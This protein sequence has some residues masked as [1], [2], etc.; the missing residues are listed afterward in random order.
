MNTMK[1]L[2]KREFWEHKG[3]FFWAPMIVG[4]IMVFFL[5]ASIVVGVVL[6]KSHGFEIN[7]DTVTSL[8]GAMTPQEAADF[9]SGLA[10]GYMGLATPL[11]MVL[12]VTVFFFC[13]GALFDDRKDR[14][15]LFWKSLPISDQA[16]VLS[17]VGVALVGAPLITIALGTVVS[18]LSLLAIC[19]GS[20][21]VGVNEFGTVLSSP[22][23]YASPF[24]VAGMLPVYVLWAAPTIGWLMMVSA[25]ARTKPFLWAVGLPVFSGLLLVWFN[26]LFNFGWNVRW[27]WHHIVGRSLGGTIPGVWFAWHPA[28]NGL[29]DSIIDGPKGMAIHRHADDM[30]ALMMQSWDMFR[31]PDLWIGV[32]AGAAMIYAAIRLRRWRDEG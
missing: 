27:Y 16:T 32:A 28:T 17:K 22:G 14:S 30:G 8:S 11:Y 13:L 18:L 9:G 7:G 26:A 21:T 1:W 2:V 5:A 31:T 29:G 3:G 12:A 23:L 20:A 24:E 4:A 19:I 6:G 15:V 25:W 10:S